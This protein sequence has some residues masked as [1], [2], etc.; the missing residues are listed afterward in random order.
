[1]PQLGLRGPLRAAGAKAQL[2]SAIPN[3]H[4]PARASF[5][6]RDGDSRPVF[7]KHPGHAELAANQSHAHRYSTLISTSTPAGRSSLVKASIVWGRE[8]LMSMSRL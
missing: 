6:H 5:D 8:S 2:D 7:S 3:L 4:H 1:M